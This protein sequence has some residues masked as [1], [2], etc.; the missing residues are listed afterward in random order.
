M[1][2]NS[3]VD[4]SGM[5]SIAARSPSG[6]SS[7]PGGLASRLE[8]TVVPVVVGALGND[9]F[10]DPA[11]VRQRPAHPILKQARRCDSHPVLCQ[12]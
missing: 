2:I 12:S 6:S 4:L 1:E 8:P 5:V 7:P 9:Q 3:T 11:A 10:D